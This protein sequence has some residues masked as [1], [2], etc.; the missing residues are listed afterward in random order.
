M[1]QPWSNYIA[2]QVYLRYIS[3]ITQLYVRYSSGL[4]ING[5]GGILDV[6]GTIY[7]LPSFAAISPLIFFL[8]VAMGY[9]SSCIE[10]ISGT[11]GVFLLPACSVYYRIVNKKQC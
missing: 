1:E 6:R 7:D 4:S 11:K 9:C 3:G 5:N 8:A 2:T 10:C